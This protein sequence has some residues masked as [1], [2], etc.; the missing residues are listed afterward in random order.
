MN[1]SDNFLLCI[2]DFQPPSSFQVLDDKALCPFTY[3]ITKL[4][5]KSLQK[6]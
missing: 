6:K 4:Q 2:N 1:D 3:T 5:T